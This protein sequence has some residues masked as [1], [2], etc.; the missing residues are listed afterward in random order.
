MALRFDTPHTLG[1]DE[2]PPCPSAECEC[3]DCRWWEPVM[4]AWWDA[5]TAEREE[6]AS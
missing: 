1:E 6:Q 2:Q 3:P 5:M 4:D